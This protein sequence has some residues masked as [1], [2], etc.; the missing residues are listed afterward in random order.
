M[1]VLGFA[2]GHWW[3]WSLPLL[4]VAWGLL[5]LSAISWTDPGL[6]LGAAGLGLANA[7]VGAVVYQAMRGLVLGTLYLAR[8]V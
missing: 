2:F 1:I 4:A 7:A 3:R 8:R 5:I 6:F